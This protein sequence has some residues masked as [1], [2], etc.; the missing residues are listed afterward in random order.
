MRL[1]LM[2]DMEGVAGMINHDQWVVPGGPYYEAGKELLTQEAN[3]AI[4]GFFA[5]GATEIVVVDGHGY[6]GVNHLLLDSRAHFMRGPYHG[7]YFSMLDPSFDA[8]AWVGQHAKAGTPF[9]QMAHTGWFNV[10]DYSINGISIGEFGQLAFCG[11]FL[12]IRSIFGAG[13]EAFVREAAELVAGIETVAVKRGIRPGSGDECNTEEYK[14]RNN[15]A[16]HIHPEIARARIR[17]GAE[18]AAR[19]FMENKEQ[20]ELLKV[21]APFH[22]EIR[23]RENGDKAAHTIRDEH[24]D[25]II[26]LMGGRPLNQE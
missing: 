19:R 10:I 5:G 7:N 25:S 26:W 17:E 9:A 12:G 14:D 6:G 20:F 21:E 23:F 13:D 22:R 8:I 11:A 16:V 3:A 18:R 1:L 24:P 2:T 15:G 4:D